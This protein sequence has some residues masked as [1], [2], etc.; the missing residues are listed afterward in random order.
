M[1][2]DGSVDKTRAL[3]QNLDFHNPSICGEYS[4]MMVILF[5]IQCK[6]L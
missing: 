5:K 3:V 6:C 2:R 4:E 1:A